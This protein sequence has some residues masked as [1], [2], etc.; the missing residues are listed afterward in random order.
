MTSVSG[1]SC[2]INRAPYVRRFKTQKFVTFSVTE[3]KCVAA[4]SCV[5]DM[6]YGKNFLESLGIKVRLP[7]NLSMDNKGGID[8]FNS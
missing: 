8:I 2:E 6:I 7:K 3:A 5:Q 1:W 4:V